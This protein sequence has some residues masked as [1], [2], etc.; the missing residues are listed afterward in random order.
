MLNF[1]IEWSSLLRVANDLQATD[2]QVRLALHRALRRTEATLRRMSSKGLTQELQLRAAKA[3]R[4]RLKSIRLRKSAYGKAG[5]GVTLW[6]GLNDLPV[7]S[8]KGRPRSTA[9][10]ASFNGT[11]F[12]GAFVGR[13]KV[14]GKRTIFK[15]QGAA[16]LH[17]SEQQLP[18]EDKAIVFIEDQVFSQVED[19]FWKNFTRDLAARVKYQ[20]KERS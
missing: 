3:L 17:I 20:F 16:R 4:K 13:S 8:F 15:R 14:K 18:I 1:D 19:I 6:Y 7:S 9:T 11:D 12:E 5:E 2:K 10:G